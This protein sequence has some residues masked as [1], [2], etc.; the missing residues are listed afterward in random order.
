MIEPR[1]CR[2]FYALTDGTLF[3]GRYL[4]AP[5]DMR[6]VRGV[7]VGLVALGEH[8]S[9]SSELQCSLSTSMSS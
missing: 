8:H 6:A 5:R 4:T 3:K 1:G 9:I 7:D 2:S